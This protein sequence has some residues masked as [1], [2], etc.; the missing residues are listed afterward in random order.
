MHDDHCS[1]PANT[2]HQHPYGVGS[3]AEVH[4]GN[5]VKQ[6]CKLVDVL[7]SALCHEHVVT[8]PTVQVKENLNMAPHTFYCV[9]MSTNMLINETDCMVHGVVPVS[10]HIQIEVHCPAITDHCNDMFD[11]CTDDSYQCVSH[12]VWN[13][14]EKYIP[15][16]TLNTDIYPLL[17]HSM[18]TMILA[19]TNL[20]SSISTVF[21][22]LPIF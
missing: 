21:L 16:F 3:N 19:M 12:S 14:N 4:L 20:F 22:G 11:P 18:A 10:V 5:N 1:A 7:S 15:R 17:F 8:L 2:W 9:L 6:L 13:G